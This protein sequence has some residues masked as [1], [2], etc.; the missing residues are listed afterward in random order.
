MAVSIRDVAA[1]AGVAVG[2]VSNV[3]NG[4]SSVN[5]DTVRRVQD[6]ITELGFV[7]NDAARQLRAGRS[8]SIGLVVLDGGN[9]FFAEVARGAQARAAEAGLAVLLAS[10]DGDAEREG[11]YLDLF[12]EQR[13]TGVLLSPQGEDPTR[14]A[15]LR[16]HGIPCVLV[17]SES[18][19]PAVSSVS[20]DDVAGGRLAAEHLLGL[21]RRRLAVIGGPESIRQVADR[22]AGARAAVAAVE[23]AV[24]EEIHTDALSVLAGREAGRALAERDAEDRPD[25]VF[26]A[27]DLLAVGVLQ[28]LVLLGGIRVPED[29][30]LIGYDDIAFATAT[31]VPLSSVRQPSSLLGAT[32]VELL[33]EQ[34]P[35]QVRFQPEL[36]VR[37]S[38][39]GPDSLGER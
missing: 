33:L 2:T 11:A 5:A 1:R 3:L 20:V 38:S 27:N 37:R 29:I 34:E 23:G 7:R 14:L 21:G 6:A 39:G 13:V 30:A 16:S 17:D 26:C 10:T 28:A 32:A 31:V 8:R 18:D 15:R 9:P 22:L 19:D 36:V 24:L 4:R 12:E 35:R 25:A